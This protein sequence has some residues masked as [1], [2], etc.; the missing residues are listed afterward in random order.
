MNIAKFIQKDLDQI[1]QLVFQAQTLEEGLSLSENKLKVKSAN[2]YPDSF[3]FF[4][5]YFF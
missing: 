4:I 2:I 5:F 1:I 3:L